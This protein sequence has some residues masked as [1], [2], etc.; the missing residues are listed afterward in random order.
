MAP[1][2]SLLEMFTQKNRLSCFMRILTGVIEVDTNPKRRFVSFKVTPS[3]DWGLCVYPPLG[4]NTREELAR[5][6]FFEGLQNYTEKKSEGNENKIIL[7]DFNFTIH[8]FFISM[9][10]N[11]L[12]RG[13]YAYDMLNMLLKKTFI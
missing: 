9:R 3:N 5:G 2:L 1:S 12:Q 8:L 7:G 11:L 4:H 6:H 13:N 10:E